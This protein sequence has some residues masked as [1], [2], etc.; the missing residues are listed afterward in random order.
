MLLPPLCDAAF[1]R[2]GTA[3]SKGHL[4]P[5]TGPAKE[6]RRPCD[7]FDLF[8]HPAHSCRKQDRHFVHA[9]F[10]PNLS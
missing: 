5:L 6:A 7:L 10:Q 9:V 4:A 3:C 8:N 2:D 1:D